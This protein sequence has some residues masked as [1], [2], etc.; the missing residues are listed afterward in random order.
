[1]QFIR[2]GQHS[3]FPINAPA[4]AGGEERVSAFGQIPTG[5]KERIR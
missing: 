4:L 2:F 3:T 5:E 1:M